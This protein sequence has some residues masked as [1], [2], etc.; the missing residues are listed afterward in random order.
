MTSS[1]SPLVQSRAPLPALSTTTRSAM[2]SM[3]RTFPRRRRSPT[4]PGLTVDAIA[5]M[6][7]QVVTTVADPAG[8]RAAPATD[9][10]L[11]RLKVGLL[12]LDQ[13][14]TLCAEPISAHRINSNEFCG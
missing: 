13:Y 3:H 10:E 6:L 12:L 8:H 2:E 14:S 9:V 7:T 4:L 5:S 11:T 1:I